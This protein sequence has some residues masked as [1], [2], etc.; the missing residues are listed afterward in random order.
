MHQQA[1]VWYRQG[2]LEEAK[3]EFS[4]AFE[5]FEKLGATKDLEE[6]RDLLREIDPTGNEA[7]G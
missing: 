6:C 7:V 4:R 1:W 2:R 3:A 5:T